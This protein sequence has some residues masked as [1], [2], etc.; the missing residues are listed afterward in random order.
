MIKLSINV[1]AWP[2]AIERNLCMK[3]SKAAASVFFSLIM[4]EY[5]PVWASEIS[6]GAYAV[7][8][9]GSCGAGNIPGTILELD[10]FFDS[11]NFA[12]NFKKNFYWKDV[13]VKNSDW[14]KEG[15]Y[16]Q[17]A[18]TDS[19][20]DGSDASIL[21]YIA[22]HG[23][24]SNGV[25]KALAGSKNNGGCYIPTPSLELG[26]HVSRYTILSTCQGLKI[27]NGDY[28]N[29][30]GE[31]P[32]RTWKNTAK[33]LNCIFGY[34]NN[35]AD[36]D[37]YGEF[38]LDNIK[39][40]STPLA[41]AFMDASE[42]VSSGNIPAVLCYGASEA[43]AANY[44]ASNKEFETAS[45]PNTASAWVYRKLDEWPSSKTTSAHIPAALRL[46]PIKF[47]L[48]KLA[49]TF[50]GSNVKKSKNGTALTYSSPTGNVSLDR[51]TGTLVI[52]NYLVE[53]AKDAL[54]PSASE[55]EQIASH[56]LQLSGI[57]KAAGGLLITAT[58]ED[59]LGGESGIKSVVSR[60]FT[61]RQK[62]A[63]GLTLSQQGTVDVTIGAGGVITEIRSAL[64][65]ADNKFRV[66]QRSTDLSSRLE[67]LEAR[68]IESIAAKSPGVNYRVL[69]HRIGYDAG[70][71]HKRKSFAP[72]VIEFTIE[73]SMGEFSR[74]YKELFAL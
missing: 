37:E 17:S 23:I 73:A 39:D 20:F 51:K 45:R 18:E 31:N 30:S 11:P 59:V 5:G 35:M 62:L 69:G 48:E 66:A 27:G 57:T 14:I 60:K 19:G 36:A 50:L 54:V 71:F 13:S 43:D 38:L 53:E 6:V 3:L 58:S 64:V 40:G 33:G 46:S 44:I 68:A 8:N 42:S 7:A 67:E 63:G 74:R 25:Y 24:T 55:A 26:N 22:S 32:S 61:F 4:S 65:Q 41:K 16:R 47:N 52:R 29:A 70:H 56:A 49:S 9:H 34:S 72:A 15:D 10:K 1:A 21:T 28:P 12:G 2:T